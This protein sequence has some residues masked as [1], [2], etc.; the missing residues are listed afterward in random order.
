MA[1]PRPQPHTCPQV[2]S[3]WR[4]LSRAQGFKRQ[5]PRQGPTWQQMDLL[6]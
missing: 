3:Q 1:V 2:A 4:A 6:R 5:Q